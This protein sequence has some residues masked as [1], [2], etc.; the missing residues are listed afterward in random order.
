MKAG[1]GFSR[2]LRSKEL[3]S[4]LLRRLV[5]LTIILKALYIIAFAVPQ[6][7]CQ[8]K[9]TDNKGEEAIHTLSTSSAT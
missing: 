4:S 5:L 2:S 1:T 3:A 6:E 7:K 8:T 9:E